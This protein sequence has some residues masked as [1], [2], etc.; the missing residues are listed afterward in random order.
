MAGGEKERL[1]EGGG[2]MERWRDDT[3]ERGGGR[4]KERKEEQGGC[5]S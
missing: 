1:N 2:E 4:D 5:R 3:V